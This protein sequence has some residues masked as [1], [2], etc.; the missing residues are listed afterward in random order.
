MSA[1]RHSRTKALPRHLARRLGRVR[2]MDAHMDVRRKYRKTQG[3]MQR[4]QKRVAGVHRALCVP[5][6]SR[7][8]GLLHASCSV[9]LFVCA[10]TIHFLRSATRS[11]TRKGGEANPSAGARCTHTEPDRTPG[12]LRLPLPKWRT[13]DVVR[14]GSR[15]SARQAIRHK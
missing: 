15:V 10:S 7:A 5:R 3:G 12:N 11:C 1:H 6:C 2:D 14:C 4:R 9:S 8:T 13:V